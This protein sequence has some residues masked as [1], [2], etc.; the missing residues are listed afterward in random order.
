MFW[1]ALVTPI[2]CA[3]LFLVALAIIASNSN[4]Q[5]PV[6]AGDSVEG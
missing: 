5:P 6:I 4:Y 1:V 3:A 2:V